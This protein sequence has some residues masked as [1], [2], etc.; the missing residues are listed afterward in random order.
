MYT[1]TS[2]E[3]R[4]NSSTYPLRQ[5][6]RHSY[7]SQN[8]E[9]R[10]IDRAELVKSIATKKGFDL[11]IL[12]NAPLFDG[13]KLSKHN[14]PYWALYNLSHDP[15]WKE[16]KFPIPA[17]HLRKLND[18]HRAGVEFDVLY[19]AH[20][21]PMDFK[22]DRDHLELSLIAPPPPTT[23]LRLAHSLG[24]VADSILA[25]YASVIKIPIKTL[26]GVSKNNFALLRDPILI[27]AVIQPGI[28]PEPGIP[29]VWFLL[30][31]WRW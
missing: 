25:T 7:Q 26:A 5:I 15:L 20:E 18:L 10:L 9:K 31:A 4:I 12:G 16:D 30:A 2:N 1:Q 29:A 28:N 13:Y 27:G 6:L 14:N 11:Q 22:P 8:L 21:L 3:A 17:K 19:V 24:F 23:A